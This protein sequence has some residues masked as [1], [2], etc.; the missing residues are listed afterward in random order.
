MAIR[1]VCLRG[2]DNSIS[3]GIAN[4]IGDRVEVQLTVDIDPM[5]LSRSDADPE[6]AGD[7]SACPALR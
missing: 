4:E 6:Q 5:R 1:L 2:A 7:L 3:D